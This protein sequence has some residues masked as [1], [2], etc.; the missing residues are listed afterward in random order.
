[1]I[2]TRHRISRILD[3]I[4]Y[5][6][7]MAKYAVIF[8]M[9]GVIADTN[10][11]HTKAFERFLDK[12]NVPYT[13]AQFEQHMYGTHNSFVTRYFFKRDIPHQ[14]FLE[15]EKE[16]EGLFLGFY[17]AEA[18][19]IAGF[20]PLLKELRQPAYKPAIATS[21]PSV[22]LDLIVDALDIRTL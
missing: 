16:K 2:R 1:N 6:C 4:Q 18:H 7:S 20:I 8:D 12:Y 10:P 9:D 19:A 15:L 3:V 17:A 13:L 5:L 11:Y 22:N 14:E 21:A